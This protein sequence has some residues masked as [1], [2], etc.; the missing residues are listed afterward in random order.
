MV[1]DKLQIS[2]YKIDTN[3]GC[4]DDCES[5]IEALSATIQEEDNSYNVQ[6]IQDSI[7]TDYEIILLYKKNS[8][9]PKWKRFLSSI[10]REDQ[11][12]LKDNQSWA[13]GF[14][15]LISH[16]S[17]HS[18]YA[19]CGGTG[20][21]AIQDVID[22]DFGIDIISR[23]IKKEDK[24]LKAIK[25]KSVMGGVLGSTK[26]FRKYYN[27]YENDSF[28]KIYQELNASLDTNMLT[29]RFGFSAEDIKKDSV[30]VAKSSF[31]INKSI[32][33]PQLLTI[34]DGC[35]DILINLNPIA[36]NNVVKIVKKRNQSLIG[37][38]ENE[39][40]NQLWKRYQNDTASIDFDLCQKEY[41]AY[42]TASS[43]IVKKN[44][45]Q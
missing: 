21:F 4:F 32:T 22:N 2:I 19:V 3:H 41:E 20:Y 28:G 24:I 27:L 25:E 18:L 36:I 13:E 35:E 29:S 6:E 14:V 39:L 23:L 44:I 1:N 34:V 15:L 17:T 5:L 31:R 26:Y 9:N 7:T 40:F 42:L 12:V 16:N 45:S 43:Y 10:A 37:Q 30:C 8:Q 38:L 11:D 33:F